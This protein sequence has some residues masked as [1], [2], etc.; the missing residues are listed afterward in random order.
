MTNKE[1]K[2]MTNNE[3]S[4]LPRF[5]TDLAPRGEEYA[6]LVIRDD[7]SYGWTLDFAYWRAQADVVSIIQR[8]LTGKRRG[9]DWT[10]YVR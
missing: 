2:T 10:V 5:L 9:S 1:N 7:E 3:T 6:Y 4:D 8:T